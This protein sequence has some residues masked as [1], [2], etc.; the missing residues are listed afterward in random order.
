[1]GRGQNHIG[2]TAATVVQIIMAHKILGFHMPDNWLD[3][4]SS[5]HQAFRRW[6][7]APILTGRVAPE[8]LDG[9]R[10]VTAV[11]GICDDALK[12]IA[13]D[14]LNFG[15]D[16]FQ[17]IAVVW[18]ALK[19][20]GMQGELAAFGMRAWGRY[21]RFDFELVR[22]VRAARTDAFHFGCVKAADLGTS[23]I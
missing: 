12:R 10:I 9:R 1:M 11:A 14:L 19:R 18:I 21:A 4:R 17:R 5:L 13:D 2:D 7:H 15:H 23:R 22:S 16:C 8:P 3:C 6:C 20:Y